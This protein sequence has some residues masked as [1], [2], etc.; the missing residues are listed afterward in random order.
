MRVWIFNPGALAQVPY[1]P[2]ARKVLQL[3]WLYLKFML[4][5]YFNGF[6]LWAEP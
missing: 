4:E 1:L 2:V 6:A 5:L 3:G